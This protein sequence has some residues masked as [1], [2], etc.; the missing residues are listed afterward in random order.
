MSA[1]TTTS[2]VSGAANRYLAALIGVGVDVA[3]I[4]VDLGSKANG[5]S[6][7]V[8]LFDADGKPVTGIGFDKLGRTKREA[9]DILADRARLLEDIARL[10]V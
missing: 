4:G 6:T 7:T 9:F 8:R 3:S 1:P 5:V 2:H 10:D